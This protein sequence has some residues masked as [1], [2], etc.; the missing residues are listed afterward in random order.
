MWKT[1]Y[2]GK[3]NVS[4]SRCVFCVC[5]HVFSKSSWRQ[6]PFLSDISRTIYWIHSFGCFFEASPSCHG[7]NN[8]WQGLGQWRAGRCTGAGREHGSTIH[9]CGRTGYRRSGSGVLRRFLHKKKGY[10]QNLWRSM[11][12]FLELFVWVPFHNQTGA[13]RSFRLKCRM[14]CNKCKRTPCEEG[15]SWC[16]GCSAW[17]A[18][19][20]ELGASWGSAALRVVASDVVVHAVKTVRSL[21]QVSSS[22]TSASSAGISRDLKTTTAKAPAPKP[23]LPRREGKGVTEVKKELDDEEY[24]FY[25]EE[26]EEEKDKGS[27][28]P[29]EPAHPPSAAAR[30]G[31]SGHRDHR[32]EDRRSQEKGEHHRD[33]ER[34]RKRK[35]TSK[36]SGRKHQ[37]QY[38][39]L[40][41]PNVR[42]HR[43]KPGTYWD[44]TPT[45]QG[46][47]A[48]ER[49][50]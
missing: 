6:Q 13:F 20:Q 46:R 48:L 3:H 26:S 11:S 24:E 49:R 31:S 41:D 10:L 1:S 47:G 37:R 12:W 32:Q 44:S 22:L 23:P 9:R 43:S 45:S 17:E 16:L 18:L 14:L 7:H 25:S 30:T 33:R 34:T 42:L 8:P 27:Q 35:R 15:D 19:G 38:R 5:Y 40:E 39:A 2:E 21:R 50:R 28:R 36:R 4:V 29:P